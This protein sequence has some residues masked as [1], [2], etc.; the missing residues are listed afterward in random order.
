MLC[1]H[2]LY[3]ICICIVFNGYIKGSIEKDILHNILMLYTL[4]TDDDYI[5]ESLHLPMSQAYYVHTQCH[6]YYYF[7]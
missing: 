7:V 6:T 2:I 1:V 4:A 5:N 3:I